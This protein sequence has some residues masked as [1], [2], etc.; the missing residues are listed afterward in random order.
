MNSILPI[1]LPPTAHMET[2]MS[3]H[4][5]RDFHTV[6]TSA[7]S[8]V[9]LTMG[10]TLFIEVSDIARWNSNL[11]DAIREGIWKVTFIP[12]RLT[13]IPNRESYQRRIEELV[14]LGNDEGVLLREESEADFWNLIRRLDPIYESS[15]VLTDEG[16]LIA[17]WEKDEDYFDVE[18]LGAN[19]LEYLAS[20]SC[21]ESDE[22]YCTMDK[23]QQR[24]NK[25]NLEGLL[26]IW[27]VKPLS[28][29][30]MWYTT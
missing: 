21:D 26:G 24:I 19:N 16:N 14:E 8:M 4:N 20:N 9:G 15:L 12:H 18:F 2:N 10:D 22:G 30:T 11:D 13:A 1:S 5:F 3:P 17:T 29:N 27:N 7:S 25:L 6:V 23:I 28:M